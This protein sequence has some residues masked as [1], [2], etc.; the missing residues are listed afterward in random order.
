MMI[1]Y[2]FARGPIYLLTWQFIDLYIDCL[3]TKQTE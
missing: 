1:Q 3:G 2:Q